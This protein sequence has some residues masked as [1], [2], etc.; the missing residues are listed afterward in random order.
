M[1]RDRVALWEGLRGWGRPWHVG[2]G[3]FTIRRHPGPEACVTQFS[4][5]GVELF[6]ESGVEL[7]DHPEAELSMARL[8]TLEDV[9]QWCAETGARD[10]AY[11]EEQR[12]WNQ[13]HEN[14]DASH[15]ATILKRVD[16]IDKRLVSVEKK[17]IWFCALAAG[18][19]GAIGQLIHNLL[20]V[21]PS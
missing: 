3:P 8:E 2:A 11:W 7:L 18:A 17:I 16:N 19:G 15:H 1:R 20:A 6:D 4:D 14:V 5:S 21:M 13:H 10:E 9:K 12:R